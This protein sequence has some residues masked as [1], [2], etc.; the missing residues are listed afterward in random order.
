MFCFFLG[1]F[2]L[3]HIPIGKVRHLTCATLYST[4][5]IHCIV[6]V[7]YRVAQVKCR[8][9]PMAKTWLFFGLPIDLGQCFVLFNLA[10]LRLA[11]QNGSL[12][13]DLNP[14]RRD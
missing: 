3:A 8:T 12:V 7:L 9:F 2:S 6:H 1:G 11:N 10:K 5:T 13:G 14:A 4:C